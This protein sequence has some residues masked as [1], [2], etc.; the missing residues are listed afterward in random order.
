MNAPMLGW[1]LGVVLAAA[2]PAAPDAQ[3]DVA[4]LARVHAKELR[5]ETVPNVT[6]KFDGALQNQTVHTSDRTNLPDEVQPHTTYR[7]IGIRL[8]I[9]STL[10]DIEQILDE[11]LGSTSKP[12]NP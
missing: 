5:F 8:T 11:A 3:P 12:P 2:T 4:I 9:T 6:V 10:P 7:D 1:W